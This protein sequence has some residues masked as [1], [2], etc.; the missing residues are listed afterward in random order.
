MLELD[1]VKSVVFSQMKSA[2]KLDYALSD[3]SSVPRTTTTFVNPR[4]TE[5]DEKMNAKVVLMGQS[6]PLS[7]LQYTGSLATTEEVGA[8][9]KHVVE[10]SI[11]SSGP[12]F[13]KF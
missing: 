3:K 12:T 6:V 13:L 4:I 10:I 8:L 7:R 11:C 9:L 5:I 2:K 1:G